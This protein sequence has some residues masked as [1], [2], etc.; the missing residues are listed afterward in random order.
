M[1]CCWTQR[2]LLAVARRAFSMSIAFLEIGG[3]DAACVCEELGNALEIV[4]GAAVD[5]P[6]AKLAGIYEGRRVARLAAWLLR[7]AGAP[8][9]GLCKKLANLWRTIICV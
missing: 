9:D 7:R 6:D 8:A 5:W 2:G 4:A 3:E 1:D